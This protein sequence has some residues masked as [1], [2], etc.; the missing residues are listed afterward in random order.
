MAV[1]VWAG[2]TASSV[3]ETEEQRIAV[4]KDGAKRAVA[5][6]ARRRCKALK[7]DGGS[8][9]GRTGIRCPLNIPDANICD[10]DIPYI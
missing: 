9:P 4:A 7:A 1:A 5:T 8:G 3:A 2:Q 10:L 6:R